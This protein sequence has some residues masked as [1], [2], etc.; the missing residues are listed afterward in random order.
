MVLGEEGAV[1]W[2]GVGIW[3]GIG[4]GVRAVNR[5]GTEL[6]LVEVEKRAGTG[7]SWR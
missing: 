2:A 1:V 3:A 6:G 7:A 5:W 4:G